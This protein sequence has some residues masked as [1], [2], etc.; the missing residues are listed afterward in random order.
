VLEGDGQ[1]DHVT[2]L[3]L[4]NSR[5][6]ARLLLGHVWFVLEPELELSLSKS[7]ILAVIL[8]R[9]CYEGIERL[10]NVLN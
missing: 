10:Q 6:S 2:Y 1:Y 3:G 7:P 5:G 9:I 4:W 8:R